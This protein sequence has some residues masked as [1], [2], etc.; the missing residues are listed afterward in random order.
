MNQIPV[1]TGWRPNFTSEIQRPP[2]TRKTIRRDNK[3]IIAHSLP[4]VA[5]YNH[6]SLWPKFK[7]FMTEHDELGLGLALHSEVWEKK[8][9]K[10]HKKI[11]EEMLEKYNITR[12]CGTLR[13]PFF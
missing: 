7:S 6:R 10:T 9:D 8:E 13:V 3:L 12:N 2:T 1:I 11:I 4:T 5:V